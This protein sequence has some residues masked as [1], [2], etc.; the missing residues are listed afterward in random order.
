M[1]KYCLLAL[2]G[3]AVA[4]SFVSGVVT[5]PKLP[6]GE[7]LTCAFECCESLEGKDQGYHCCGMDNKRIVTTQDDNQKHRAERFVAYSNG[8][9]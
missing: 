9:Q 1:Q 7:I 6:S 3:L 5:C 4:G 2:I 8:F